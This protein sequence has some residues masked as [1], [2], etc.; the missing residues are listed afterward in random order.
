MAEESDYKSL[1]EYPVQILTGISASMYGGVDYHY[2]SP[3][4][5][6]EQFNT[7]RGP[8]FALGY[9]DTPYLIE[10]DPFGAYDPSSYKFEPK[11]FTGSVAKFRIYIP[12]GTT[13][14]RMQAEFLGKG[15]TF[16]AAVR[17]DVP[18]V[19]DQ[20]L[21]TAEYDKA[22]FERSTLDDFHKLLDG[23]ELLFAYAGI[24][25]IPAARGTMDLS[26]IYNIS[27]KDH[28]TKGRWLFFSIL[29]PAPIDRIWANYV[30]NR[31][32]FRNLY[33]L[34]EY[35]ASGNPLSSAGS[36]TGGGT[37]PESPTL[38]GI[39]VTPAAMDFPIYVPNHGGGGSVGSG[40]ESV[41]TP[42]YSFLVESIP[43]GAPL[44]P[45]KVFPASDVQ[46]VGRSP[47]AVRYLYIGNTRRTTVG[48]S[49]LVTVTSREHLAEIKITAIAPPSPT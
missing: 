17:M 34:I 30:V 48:L 1:H 33:A 35:D 28:F 3:V 9:P 12:P 39:K 36:S 47:S 46:E 44:P 16:A 25:N 14:F 31:E 10:L 24:T 19:R 42:D 11:G 23:Q 45:V 26:G 5:F 2:E 15:I 29:N 21:T 13:R 20:P 43:A 41:P 40:G 4:G 7:T 49:D 32:T 18:P 22:Q 38:A 27:S 37:T 6:K 8:G